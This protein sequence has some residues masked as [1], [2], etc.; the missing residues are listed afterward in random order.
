MYS[1]QNIQFGVDWPVERP[2][3]GSL[4]VRTDLPG[5]SVF[6]YD[7]DDDVYVQIEAVYIINSEEQCA[8]ES[9]KLFNSFPQLTIHS[10]PYFG[11]KG[12]T[13]DTRYRYRLYTDWDTPLYTNGYIDQIPYAPTYKVDGHRICEIVYNSELQK[14]QEVVVESS[15]SYNSGYNQGAVGDVIQTFESGNVLVTSP[16][17]GTG[18]SDCFVSVS[19]HEKYVLFNDLSDFGLSQLTAE[20]ITIA[21]GGTK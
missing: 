7:A 5:C 6:Q 9:F 10:G 20:Q 19:G 8:G 12:L 14:F 15:K 16:S 13:S 17:S 11:Y 2:T 18:L 21:S 3:D 1:L 4:F